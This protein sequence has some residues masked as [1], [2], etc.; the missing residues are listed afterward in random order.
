MPPSPAEISAL[1]TQTRELTARVTRAAED[2]N[3]GETEQIALAL[4]EAERGLRTALRAME[5]AVGQLP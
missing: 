3:G 2:L 4:F 5:R 1:V